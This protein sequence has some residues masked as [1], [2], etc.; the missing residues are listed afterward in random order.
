MDVEQREKPLFVL[1]DRKAGN[2]PADS[3][4]HFFKIS[5]ECLER[6]YSDRPEMTEV[7]MKKKCDGYSVGEPMLVHFSL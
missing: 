2:W 3:F 5:N 1:I 4:Q 6:R 7:C